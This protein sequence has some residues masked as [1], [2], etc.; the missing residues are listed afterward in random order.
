[1]IYSVAKNAN[2]EMITEN[3]IDFKDEKQVQWHVVAK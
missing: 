3:T 1:M 2:M